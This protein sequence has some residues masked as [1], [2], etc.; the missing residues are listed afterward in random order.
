MSVQTTMEAVLRSALTLLV[1][2]VV[3]VI[4]TSP[5]TQM[6]GLAQVHYC[7]VLEQ[8]VLYYQLYYQLYYRILS[9]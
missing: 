6:A 7:H 1:P 3:D 2:I 9:C 5:L 4:L 8:N